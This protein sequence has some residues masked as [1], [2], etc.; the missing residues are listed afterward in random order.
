MGFERTVLV[1]TRT[2]TTTT[3]LLDVL[4]LIRHDPRIQVVFTHER[5]SAFNDGVVDFVR[6]LGGRLVPWEQA[7]GM[8]F[9]LAIAASEAGDL[10]LLDAPV[11]VLPHGVGRGKY[12]KNGIGDP[13]SVSGF[14]SDQ[15]VRDGRVVPAAIVLSHEEE[16][17]RL[18]ASCP[19]ALP[20]A[21][22]TGDVCLDRLLVSV[23]H[24]RRYR[25]ALGVDGH[26]RLVVLNSTWG[27][28]SMIASELGLAARLL[29][30]LPRDEY[31]VAVVLHP[32]VWFGHSPYQVRG[33]LHS[34]REAGVLLVPPHEG[35]H[36]TLVSADLLISDHGSISLYGAALGVPLLLGAFHD[37]EIV[38]GTPIAALAKHAEWL[39]RAGNLRGQVDAAIAGHDQTTYE[40]IVDRAFALRGQGSQALGDLLYRTMSLP[41]GDVRSAVR[42]VDDP[43]PEVRHVSAYRVVTGISAGTAVVLERFPAPLAEPVWLDTAGRDH[44]LAVEEDVLDTA[45]R[46]SA[47]VLLS[48]EVHDVVS[49]GRAALEANPGATVA[50]ASNVFVVRGR[51]GRFQV[52]DA[53]TETKHPPVVTDVVASAIYALTVAG[54]L[55]DG[56]T[57]LTVHLGRL[58]R[59]VRVR[60]RG[61]HPG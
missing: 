5:S 17:H 9:D 53:L 45:L 20:R 35:W 24:R 29:S 59:S 4:S 57:T 56:S 26:Q 30:S 25:R 11:V 36:A 43:V 34:A 48:S 8:R 58:T 2:V 52:Y 14:R 33:W 18:A 3:R 61:G 47:A 10:H 13:M 32:S 54:R 40:P 38:P 42:P 27:R 50:A 46:E 44:H 22:V 1:V 19:E 60:R 7:V 21:V 28:R 41:I 6:S 31:K 12:I 49:W 51:T 15:L 16:L 37:D 55:G 39:D 23:P